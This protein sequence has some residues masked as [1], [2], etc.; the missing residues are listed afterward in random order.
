MIKDELIEELRGMVWD[1]N[2]NE[3]RSHENLNLWCI[4]WRDK[5]NALLNELSEARPKG[6]WVE[7][8]NTY[9]GAFLK[10]WK[11]TNCCKDTYDFV[12][13]SRI[14]PKWKFC[15]ICGARMKREE[16]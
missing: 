12:T 13:T 1:V 14:K 3:I 4:A 11:C 15:P 5:M 10:N 6:E 7:N 2:V 8:T 16:T 9:A